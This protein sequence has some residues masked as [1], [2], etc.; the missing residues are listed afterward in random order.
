MSASCAS[1]NYGQP[2]APSSEA[3]SRTCAGTRT[4]SVAWRSPRPVQ[5]QVVA[6]ERRQR[7][8]IDGDQADGDDSTSVVYTVASTP[9]LSAPSAIISCA[10]CRPG[11]PGFT[12]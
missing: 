7:P 3:A 6:R 4:P 2:L 11:S 5:R 8:A 10:L 1:S 9:A 12:G